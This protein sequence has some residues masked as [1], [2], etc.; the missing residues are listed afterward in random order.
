MDGLMNN[1]DLSKRTIYGSIG[2]RP[3]QTDH[4]AV[5][6][7]EEVLFISFSFKNSLFRRS[8]PLTSVVYRRWHMHGRLSV[9]AEAWADNVSVWKVK[10]CWRSRQNMTLWI[11]FLLGP[12]KKSVPIQDKGKVNYYE[13]SLDLVLKFYS[14]LGQ[15]FIKSSRPSQE[16]KSYFRRFPVFILSLSFDFEQWTKIPLSNLSL[17][18][19]FLVWK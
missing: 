12:W 7:S 15:A 1:F 10:K 16:S 14:R 6:C 8:N 3:I 17:I 9:S 11:W 2:P 19:C 13:F 5:F 4:F 18:H